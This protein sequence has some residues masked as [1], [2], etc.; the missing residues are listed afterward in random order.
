MKDKALAFGWTANQKAD[1]FEQEHGRFTVEVFWN[2]GNHMW[3]WIV[4]S[5]AVKDEQEILSR[6]RELR[7]ASAKVTGLRAAS[8]LEKGALKGK[9]AGH[10]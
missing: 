9:K 7:L 2:E 1:G 3:S 10:A 6:G 5:P 4:W 8:D